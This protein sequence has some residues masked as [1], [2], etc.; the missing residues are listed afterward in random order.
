LIVGVLPQVV[1]AFILGATVDTPTQTTHHD[2]THCKSTQSTPIVL[3]VAG[4]DSGGGAGIQADIKAISATNSY[5]CSVITALTAQN[6]QRVNAVLPIDQYFIE[7]QFDAIFSDIAVDAVKIGMLGDALTIKTVAKALKQYA[8]KYIV[9][10]PV[11]V[12]TS[13]DVLLANDAINSLIEQLL[14]LADVITP[15]MPEAFALLGK[16]YTPL[17]DDEQSITLCKSLLGLGC[18][19]VLLKGGHQDGAYSTDYWVNNNQQQQ[20][21]SARVNTKN[22][23]GTGCTLSAAIASYLAQGNTLSQAIERAKA[24]ISQA[25]SHADQLRIGKGHGPVHH[26]YA[27]NAS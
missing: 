19:S 17:T 23:H 5:A 26:F 16:A 27:L 6:T 4:S 22:T 20:F 24:Y 9:L 21:T 13:G 1:R 14:P 8:P 18:Q 25:I 12:A 2:T 11:M 3:T 10:D 15:N 7:Q